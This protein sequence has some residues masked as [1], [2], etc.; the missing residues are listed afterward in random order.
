MLIQVQISTIHQ[1]DLT[2]IASHQIMASLANLSTTIPSK[3]ASASM[4]LELSLVDENR[5]GSAT[6]LAKKLVIMISTVSLSRLATSHAIPLIQLIIG[7]VMVSQIT[8][9]P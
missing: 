3:K 1:E 7:K 5:I 4:M 2:Y 9:S 6:G 8:K